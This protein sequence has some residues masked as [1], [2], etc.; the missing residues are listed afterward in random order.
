MKG[1]SA[2]TVLVTVLTHLSWNPGAVTNKL[3]TDERSA[4]R[5]IVQIGLVPVLTYHLMPELY[6]FL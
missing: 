3:K 2:P 4:L 6:Q 5:E 1:G